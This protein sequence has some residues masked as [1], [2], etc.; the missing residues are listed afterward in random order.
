MKA[1]GFSFEQRCVISPA[2]MSSMEYEKAV[3]LV[4]IHSFIHKLLFIHSFNIYVPSRSF[5]PSP[6]RSPNLFYFNSVFA[7]L[8]VIDLYVEAQHTRLVALHGMHYCTAQF[9]F[10]YIW[11]DCMF[12]RVKAGEYRLEGPGIYLVVMWSNSS[13]RPTTSS[14]SAE[15]ISWSWRG[16]SGTSM[17]PSSLSGLL[18]TTAIGLLSLYSNHSRYTFKFQSHLFLN[19]KNSARIQFLHLSRMRV[20]T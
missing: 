17:R 4:F 2:S 11:F 13:T 5:S 1:S 12:Q 10:T 20:R 16:T 7:S 8:S 15:L 18:Q 19:K 14:S 6:S 9:S 3:K